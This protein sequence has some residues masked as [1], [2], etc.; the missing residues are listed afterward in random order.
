[1]QHVT[2]DVS[3]T[4]SSIKVSVILSLARA[5]RFPIVVCSEIWHCK[6]PIF[7]E[8]EFSGGILT[9]FILAEQL[10]GRSELLQKSWLVLRST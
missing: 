3:I 4:K 2:E 10:G 7:L 9:G 1:M 6:G 5:S 8:E